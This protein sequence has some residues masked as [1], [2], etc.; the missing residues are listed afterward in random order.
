MD[1][2]RPVEATLIV[3]TLAVAASPILTLVFGGSFPFHLSLLDAAF[4]LVAL[5]GLLTRPR[6]SLALISKNVA[7]FS[8]SGSFLGAI[9]LSAVVSDFHATVLKEALQ[10]LLYL[11]LIPFILVFEPDIPKIYSRAGKVLVALG[12]VI[13]P[14][15]FILYGWVRFDPF[16]IHANPTG[17]LYGL[18][19]I[20]LSMEGQT[21]WSVLAIV[22]AA[23]TFSRSALGA[24]FATFSQAA[25]RLANF[26]RF[27][28]LAVLSAAL[29]F[30]GPPALKGFLAVRDKVMEMVM[31]EESEEGRYK[32]PID[33]V[34]GKGYEAVRFLM[35]EA[36]VHLWREDPLLG[37]GLGT[38][39]QSLK[40]SC[41]EG[42]LPPRLCTRWV[43][44]VDPHNVFLHVLSETG[45]VGLIT[46]LAF[47]G[48][49]VVR[50]WGNPLAFS[51]L[52]F[53]LLFGLLQ[54]FPLFT[55]NLAPLTW[56]LIM[57]GGGIV[58]KRE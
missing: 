23:F 30:V 9:L 49:L 19:A 27:L 20:V 24:L 2:V 25:V 31:V 26:R 32:P 55:R 40:S 46:F 3:G 53:A 35:W 5:A 52:L 12:I 17:Y 43:E 39:R 22:I 34:R 7:Y 8:L 4:L 21:V 1:K 41:S 58:W 6:E 45:L 56:L 54:P 42:N 36:A 37:T 15:Y 28:G 38:Y 51:V 18:F 57:W 10:M 33:I 14:L 13:L 47:M 50:V 44:N 48:F 11:W 29:L 16:G